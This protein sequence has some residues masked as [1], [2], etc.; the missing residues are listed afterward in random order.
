M[1]IKS[2]VTLASKKEI[3]KT[4]IVKGPTFV[5]IEDASFCVLS[6]KAIHTVSV[7][8]PFVAVKLAF[9]LLVEV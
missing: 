6:P 9:I 1:N 2:L 3:K 4:I 7:G 8:M 5:A